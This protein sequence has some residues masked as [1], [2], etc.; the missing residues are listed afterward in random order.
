MFEHIHQRL[1]DRDESFASAQFGK[2]LMPERPNEASRLNV[3]LK[4]RGNFIEQP[5]DRGLW[6]PRLE[7]IRF[8]RE[9]PL[10][11]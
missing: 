2:G 7:L 4:D 10:N 5:K 3:N 6:I 9:R 8:E 11:S 1:R